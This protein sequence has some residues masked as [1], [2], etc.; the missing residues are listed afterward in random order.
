MEEESRFCEGT[1]GMIRTII[2]DTTTNLPVI[3]FKMNT[4]P[5]PRDFLI[6]N[7]GNKIKHYNV[8]RVDFHVCANDYHIRI[9]AYEVLDV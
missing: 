1:N 7:V 2:I 4:P 5:H 6:V 8:E 9:Y 3:E